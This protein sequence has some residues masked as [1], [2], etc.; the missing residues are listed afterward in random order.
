MII[1]NKYNNMSFDLL[2]AKKIIIYQP[3]GGL[4]DNL[5]F[6]TLPELFNNKG[7]MCYI[8]INNSTRND[9]EVYDLVWGG[10]SIY[11]W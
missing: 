6:S 4:G 7:I 11:Y 5:A 3:Y 2:S 9:D 1:D 10:K 8:H